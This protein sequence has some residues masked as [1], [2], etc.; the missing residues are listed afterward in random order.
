M[1]DEQEEMQNL[2]LIHEFFGD[3]AA[4]EPEREEI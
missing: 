4:T 2:E 3:G 1:R